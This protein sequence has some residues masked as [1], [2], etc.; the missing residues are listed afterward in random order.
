[1]STE[2]KAYSNSSISL[3]MN[4]RRV[5]QGLSLSMLSL[6]GCNSIRPPGVNG[7]KLKRGGVEIEN[8]DSLPHQITV[9]VT[10][11]QSDDVYKSMAL[12]VRPGKRHVYSEFITNEGA[13][14]VRVTNEFGQ[15]QTVPLSY[16]SRD[17][18]EVEFRETGGMS[19]AQVSLN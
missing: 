11:K 12:N 1:M 15:S 13:Y 19:V 9:R 6:A 10:R 18:I 5:L 3:N 8:R 17:A 16:P 4:R 7:D 2:E 14:E